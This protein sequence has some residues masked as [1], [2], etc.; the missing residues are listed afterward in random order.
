MRNKEREYLE[1]NINETETDSENKS[2]RVLYRGINEFKNS[3]HH[4]TTLVRDESGDL[5][6]DS[7]VILYRWKNYFCQVLNVHGV[8]NIRQT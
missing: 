2:T 1:D 3:Y 6:A 8:N 4:K 5:L 7:H